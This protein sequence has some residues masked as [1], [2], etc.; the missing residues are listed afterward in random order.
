MTRGQLASI[1]SSFALVLILYLGC[2]RRSPEFRGIEESRSLNLEL[3]A[4]ENLLQEAKPALEASDLAQLANY[5]MLLHDAIEDSTKVEAMKKLSGKWYELGH[6]AIAGHYAFEIAL[7]DPNEGSWSIAG[8]TYS[9]CI[10]RAQNQELKDYCTTKAV[11][12]FENAISVNPD[13]VDHKINLALAYV[14]NPSTNN[15][16]QGIQMLLT[17]QETYPKNVGVLTN[18]ARLAIKTGQFDRAF[19]RL[20]AALQMEPDNVLANCLMASTLESL[21]RSEEAVVFTQKCNQ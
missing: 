11:S 14:E 1:L 15:P 21:N 12:A 18:L 9:I 16:M 7:L 20:T 3:I 8:T 17:L 19:E 13:N 10:Q 5:E 4:I 6:P 2:E